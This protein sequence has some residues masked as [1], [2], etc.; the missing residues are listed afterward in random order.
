MKK[1]LLSLLLAAALL[2]SL[3]P[4]FAAGA[5]K[6]VP[7][8]SWY[9]DAVGRFVRDG[10][11]K[12][13]SETEFNPDGTM[14]RA[15]MVTILFRM[16]GGVTPEEISGRF[17]DV[18]PDTWY[19]ESVAWAA[20]NGITKGM[21][22]TQFAPD[23]PI[24]REQLAAFLW[25]YMD[26]RYDFEHDRYFAEQAFDASDPV[27][28]WA[29]EPMRMMIGAGILK[30]RAQADGTVLFEAKAA[31]TRAEAVTM[32]DRMLQLELPDKEPEVVPEPTEPPK[33][34]AS[35]ETPKPTVEP[36]PAPEPADSMD[37]IADASLRLLRASHREG[38][39]T[40]IS[41]LSMLYALDLLS[42]GADGSTLADLENFFGISTEELT[43][44]LGAYLDSMDDGVTKLNCANS[45]W[46][47]ETCT[48]LPDYAARV[49]EKLQA[50]VRSRIFNEETVR[51]MNGWVSDQTDGMIPGVLDQL[52]PDDLLVLINAILFKANWGEAYTGA[53]D[54]VFHTADG[55]E[56]N[57]PM[58]AGEEYTYLSGEDVIGFR[59]PFV[60]GRY[61][62]AVLVPQNDNSPEKLLR[63]LDGAAL[64]RLLKG[65]RYDE[66][67]TWMP[68]FKAETQLDLLEVLSD[69]GVTHLS[70]LGG[71]SEMPMFVSRGIHKA[72]IDVNEGGV[73]AA[74]V[75][76]IVASKSAFP[77]P[78]RKIAT[79]VADRPYVYMIV[80]N[81][82]LLPIFTGVYSQVE[83]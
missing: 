54:R 21:S 33:P 5:F 12:G 52:Y 79:V 63:S 75:T 34:T 41:P 22:K 73:S 45:V 59:K 71:I 57:T 58:M 17:A 30:G 28:P 27:S 51:E 60:G 55:S 40:V 8:S 23:E 42:E 72:V 48:L 67:H 69:V 37:A 16:G 7:E 10:Y 32:L 19:E 70:D 82:T 24:T 50:E 29:E 18:G 25:R 46:V 35:A 53:R 11:V 2:L 78:N 83:G 66:V 1:R 68:K 44:A 77:D 14:T 26:M 6:D 62:F 74:A 56:Q 13:V 36:K 76:A 47:N 20:D 15:M 61:S 80:D 65:E 64:R 81:E 9:A 38:E 39:N 4:V 43:A 49:Q 31:C 3:S